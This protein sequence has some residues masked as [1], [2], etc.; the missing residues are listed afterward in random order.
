MQ[1]PSWIALF[2]R[3]P[4]KLH[5]SL[6]LTLIT[7]AEI[8]MQSILRLESDYAIIRG[9]MSGST[10]AGRVIVLPYNQIVNLA[11]TKRMLE[12]EVQ[13]IFGKILEQVTA[14]TADAP[15]GDEAAAPAEPVEEVPQEVEETPNPGVTV[16]MRTILPPAPAS[17][18][19]SQP[20]QP[21][22]S[23][24]L[25]RLRARLAEQGK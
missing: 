1:G 17:P 14:Q 15:A 2:N 13:A 19:K 6:A 23:I 24:L 9:R 18:G 3:I 4:G 21:S 5:D 11:F 7:G 8:L 10:D 22:K 25:A 12:A 20:Q 16:A